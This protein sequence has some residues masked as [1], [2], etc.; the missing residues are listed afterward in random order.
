MLDTLE[1]E[2]LIQSL[3]DYQEACRTLHKAQ[4]NFEYSVA[5]WTRDERDEVSR[6]AQDFSERL[7]KIIIDRI[8]IYL[9]QKPT[10]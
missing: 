5:Y 8:D 10:P 4:Q 7:E 1:I 6:C 3:Q 2:C 9:Q